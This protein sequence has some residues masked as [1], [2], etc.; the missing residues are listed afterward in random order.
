MAAVLE[1]LAGPEVYCVVFTRDENGL[2]YELHGIG[3]LEA[4]R[5]VLSADLGRVAKEL[6]PKP[7]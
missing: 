5:G 4:A 7:G 6:E 1:E 3:D 2:N